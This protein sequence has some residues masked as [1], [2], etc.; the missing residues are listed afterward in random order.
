[1]RTASIAWVLLVWSTAAAPAQPSYDLLLKGGHVIDPANGIDEVRDVALAGSKIAAVKRDIPASQARQTLDVTGYYVT[2]GLIDIHVHVYGYSGW[3]FPDQTALPSGVTTVVDAGGAGWKTFED[4]RST[5]IEKSQTRVLAFL[6]IVGRG[7]LGADAEND[8][9]D[10]D[11]AAT[12][13]VVRRYP[14]YIVGI[15][16]A[17]FA[18]PTWDAV[19]RAVQA[20]ELSATPVMVDFRPLPER[21]YPDLILKHMRAGDMH[22]HFYGRLTPLLDD[23]GNVQPYALE[24]RKKG[25]LFDVGHGAG[26]FWFRIASPAIG[27]GFLPDTISTDLHKT[28]LLCCHATLA[29][30]LSKFLNLGLSLQDVI[31]RSTLHAAR[32]IRRS[33]LGTLSPGAGAD[34]AVFELQKGSFGF[35]DS[36]R[37]RLRGDQN[38]DCVLTVR[39]G[40]IVWDRDGIG[41]PDWKKAGQYNVLNE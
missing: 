17:H 34:V 2:P 41:R 1:M 35:I 24:A 36:G 40:K 23:E 6:N 12:A 4:F 38:L 26:S 7:M 5:L 25:V 39:E 18:R 15:K 14:Q 9:S 8:V 19:D 32:A 37:A 27:Q 31:T 29:K 20:G 28:S 22:T 30:T 11:P 16:T 13:E 3:L 10:M 21:N 33:E